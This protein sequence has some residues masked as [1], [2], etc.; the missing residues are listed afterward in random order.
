MVARRL[1]FLRRPEASPRC[2]EHAHS[3]NWRSNECAVNEMWSVRRST[4]GNRA[5]LAVAGPLP[6]L[7]G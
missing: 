5:G 4:T 2:G 3:V 6:A 7:A 1:A